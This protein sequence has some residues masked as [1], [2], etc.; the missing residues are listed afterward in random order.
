MS[1]GPD[2]RC[3]LYC[4]W[5]HIKNKCGSKPRCGYCSG[6]HQRS[7]H[8]SNVM[9]YTAKQG[10]LCGHTVEKCPNCKEI[11]IVLSS[12]CVKKTEATEEVR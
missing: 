11:H 4:E 2:R 6:H 7:D 3:K 12:R 9:G 8:K 1:E 5:G 10:S